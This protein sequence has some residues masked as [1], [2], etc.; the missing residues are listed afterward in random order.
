M[1]HPFG[2]LCLWCAYPDQF[3]AIYDSAKRT[4]DLERYKRLSGWSPSGLGYELARLWNLPR[5][6]RIVI[7]PDHFNLKRLSRR[8]ALLLTISRWTSD[9]VAGPGSA[10]SR[11]WLKQI[12]SR[13]EDELDLPWKTFSKMVPDIL[14]RF[15]G[16]LP[17][18]F[19]LLREEG[20]IEML[21]V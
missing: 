16:E 9:Y 10:G 5:T 7:C 15:Q 18:D 1:M 19:A 11:V 3:G 4:I 6:I 21:P 17:E 8:E 12:R 13:L 14:D 20:V 2:L